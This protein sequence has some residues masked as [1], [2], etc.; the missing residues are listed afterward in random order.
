MGIF[1]CMNAER[2]TGTVGRLALI[3][4]P[5]S[6]AVRAAKYPRT[7]S[8]SL[9]K[10]YLAQPAEHRAKL[11]DLAALAGIERNC[12]PLNVTR[13]SMLIPLERESSSL[14]WC[15]KMHLASG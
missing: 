7:P 6:F 5:E 11:R 13:K 8:G 10:G 12:C 15:R 4:K 3:L 14:E 1:L 9:W 2:D